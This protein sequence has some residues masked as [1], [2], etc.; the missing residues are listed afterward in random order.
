MAYPGDCGLAVFGIFSQKHTVVDSALG[1]AVATVKGSEDAAGK[2]RCGHL[3]RNAREV[4]SQDW[5]SGPCSSCFGWGKAALGF[6]LNLHGK[7]QKTDQADGH[8]LRCEDFFFII[9]V[10]RTWRQV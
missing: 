10:L 3:D 7:A 6:A 4:L 9:I 8:K 5:Y 1:R 2:K